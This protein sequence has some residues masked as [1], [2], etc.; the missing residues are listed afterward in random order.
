MIEIINWIAVIIAIG[1]SIEV[2]KKKPNILLVNILYSMAN[3]TLLG[4]FLYYKNYAMVFQYFVFL[5]IAV[6]G[7][8]KQWNR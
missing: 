6:T 2:S 3:I 1:G 7:V 8:K 5:I 4:V